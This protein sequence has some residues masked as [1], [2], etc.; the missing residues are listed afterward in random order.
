MAPPADP[1]AAHVA[2][3]AGTALS[4]LADVLWQERSLLHALLF[5][6]EE[7]QLILQSDRSRWLAAADEE[8]RT[9]AR[10]LQEH[11]VLRAARAEEVIGLLGLRSED[12]LRDIADAAPEPWP[13]LLFDHRE[14]LQALSLEI[15]GAATE[16]RRLL[17]IP[18]GRHD[19]TADEG[20]R[21][22]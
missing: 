19:G 18:A 5:K 9:I 20:R 17:Q 13:G 1:A 11:E 14:A 15:D 7:Q 21:S 2:D 8:L 3:D 22:G 10:Q 4:E 16:N 12:T 6:L